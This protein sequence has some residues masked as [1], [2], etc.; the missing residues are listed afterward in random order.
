MNKKEFATRVTEVLRENDT[1]KPIS[2]KKHVFHISDN[3]GNNA[4]FIVK[5]K[6]KSVIY[7]IDDTTNII[8]ACL[9]VIEDALKNGEEI[10]IH[11]FGCLGLHYRA[12]RTTIDPFYGEPCEVEARY[13]PK[14][15]YGKTLRMAARLYEL[16]LKEAEQNNPSQHAEDSEGGDI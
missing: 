4:E 12:A 11:G 15:N 8:D 2:A 7:T 16:S 9:A 1:R 14:F 10:N 5:Q 3:E 6:N 13:I